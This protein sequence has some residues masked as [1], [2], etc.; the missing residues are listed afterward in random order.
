M[1]SKG[2]KFCFP[3]DEIK[4]SEG[5]TGESDLIIRIIRMSSYIKSMTCLFFEYLLERKKYM[6]G[7]NCGKNEKIMIIINCHNN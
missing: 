6:Q 5:E 3:V 7:N 1:K 4:R 2:Q